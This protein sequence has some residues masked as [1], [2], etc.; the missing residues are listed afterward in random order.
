MTS[1]VHTTAPFALSFMS[2]NYVAKERGYGS[3][4][5]WG[6]FDAAT[7]AAFEPL[8][9]FAGRFDDLLATITGIGFDTI[10]LWFAH[11][12]WRWATLEHVAVARE[13]LARRDVRVLSLAGSVGATTDELAAACRLANDLDV[14]LIAGVGEVVHRDRAGAVAVLREHGVRFGLENHPERTPHE[15]LDTIGDDADVLG[16]T[17][18]TGWWATQS[19][20]PV[21]AIDELSDRLFHVHLKDVEEPGTHFS[22]MHGEGFANIAGCVEKLLAIGYSGPVSIEH[23]PYDRDPTDECVRML[24][25]IREQL[26]AGEVEHRV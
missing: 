26:A 23:E 25:R 7:N 15:V 11:L 17:V 12:N 2:A 21:A 9:T 22:C 1:P 16:A 20:D 19:Y 10:D 4:D 18:D 6:P 14:D 8:E 5:E 13:A 3:A 24:A